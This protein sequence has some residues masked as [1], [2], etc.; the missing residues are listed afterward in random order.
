MY[1]KSF[2]W[3]N[4]LGEY[5]GVQGLCL[6]CVQKVDRVVSTRFHL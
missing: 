6:L 4:Y 1:K 3:W 2:T 5:G